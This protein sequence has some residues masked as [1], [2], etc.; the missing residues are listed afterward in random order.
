MNLFN[1]EFTNSKGIELIMAVSFE[2][3]KLN[4]N[5]NKTNN[6]LY[7]A[8]YKGN[9]MMSRYYLKTLL[10]YRSNESG[11]CLEGSMSDIYFVDDYHMSEF[12]EI[13][14][15]IKTCITALKIK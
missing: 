10:E 3:D 13:F 14:K 12:R 1:K 2:K 9:Y 4:I 7:V 11:L 5:G 15:I 6:Q 8:F